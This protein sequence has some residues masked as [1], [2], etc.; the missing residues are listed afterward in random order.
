MCS[1]FLQL[2]L[3]SADDMGLGKTLTMISVL[4]SK[5]IKK[6]EDDEKKEGQKLDSWVSKNGNI[7]FGLE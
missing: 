7:Q 6:K 5:K 1:F 4:L 3:Y 2:G